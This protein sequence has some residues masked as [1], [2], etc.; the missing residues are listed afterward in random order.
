MA[1]ISL[2]NRAVSD[3]KAGKILIQNMDADENIVD[4]AG[5]HLQ[6]SVEKLLKFQIEMQGDEYPFTHDIAVLMDLV[7]DVPEW[8]EEYCETLIKYG[9][10]T[11]YSSL[12]VASKTIVLKLFGFLEKYIESIKPAETNDADSMPKI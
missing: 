4:I 9:V 10:K 7:D 6:Q 1:E 5:Y 12:R 11:R 3:F 2:Y 8:V